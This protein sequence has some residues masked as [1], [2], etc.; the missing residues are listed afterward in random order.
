VTEDTTPK[1][2]NLTL[3]DAATVTMG[4]EEASATKSSNGAVP[5]LVVHSGPNLGDYFAFPESAGELT[6]GRARDMDFVLRHA[7]VSRCHLKFVVLDTAK[8]RTV[9]I[10]DQGSTNGTQLNGDD[11]VDG[12][13]LRDGDMLQI[14]EIALRYRLMDPAEHAFQDDIAKRVESARTDPL[15]GLLTR[16]FLVDQLPPLL[17]AYRRNG[18]PFSLL[19]VDLDYFKSVN[20]Q[21]GHIMGD[22]VLCSVARC[23][24]TAIR[25]GDAAL[26]F[27]GE[28]FCV[29]LPGAP[30]EVALRVGERVR[31]MVSDLSF[32][33]AEGV[34][35]SITTSV[36]VAEIHPEENIAEWLNRADRALYMAKEIGRNTVQMALE[37]GEA[38]AI[39]VRKENHDQSALTQGVAAL[40]REDLD[41]SLVREF[42]D[43]RGSMAEFA[44]LFLNDAGARDE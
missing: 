17:D 25:G 19:I 29:I 39:T 32:E 1:G 4:G 22:Q 13:L 37:P 6:I 5:A 44:Q 43:L 2:A 41:D 26:R 16:R 10:V 24:C 11:L 30:G 15:T 33:N 18:E 40:S 14:G 23:L 38:T 35:F 3:G 34:P 9:E 42:N 21:H 31:S 7:S 8:G 27:G 36:G 12:C 20:D 28:E